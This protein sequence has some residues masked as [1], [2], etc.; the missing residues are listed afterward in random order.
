MNFKEIIQE[1]YNSDECVKNNLVIDFEHPDQRNKL[2]SIIMERFNCEYYVA[3]EWI[4]QAVDK[5]EEFKLVEDDFRNL[6]EA[7]CKRG[8]NPKRDDCTAADGTA[9]SGKEDKE[10]VK[11]TKKKEF[12][13]KVGYQNYEWKDENGKSA[14]PDEIAEMV[15]TST[16]P[17]FI[18]TSD[19]KHINKRADEERHKIFNGEKTGKGTTGTTAQEECANIGREIAARKDFKEPPPLAE[20]IYEEVKKRYPQAIGP[21]PKPY[22]SE[23]DLM[24]ACEKST[25]GGDTMKILQTLDKWDYAEEQ[26]DGM[27][28][29]TTDSTIVRDVLITELKKCEELKN[30]QERKDCVKYYQRELYFFQ[31]KAT[32]KS[33]TGKEGDAD[34]MIIYKGKDGKTRVAYITNKTGTGD[35][36]S[37]STIN[38]TKI[39]IQENADKFFKDPK[40]RKNG[41]KKIDKIVE[42][43][44][45]KAATFNTNFTDKIK[46]FA[47]EDEVDDKGEKT[48]KKKD[49]KK[50]KKLRDPA[51]SKALGKAMSVDTGG[52]RIVYST[53]TNPNPKTKKEKATEEAR[54]KR[55]EKYTKKAQKAPE[56]RA[57]LLGEEGAPNNNPDSK[58]YKAWRTKVNKKWNEHQAQVDAGKK[59]Q[60]SPEDTIQASIDVSGTGSLDGMGTGAQEAPYTIVRTMKATREVREQMWRCLG[61]KGKTPTGKNV[62]K[63]KK[64][65]KEC[66]KKIAKQ[67]KSAKESDKLF[68]GGVFDPEDI[69]AIYG[70]EELEE[71][72]NIHLQ[73][74][75]DIADMYDKTTKE[76]RTEDAEWAKRN[77]V[78]DVPPK[79]GPFTKAYVKGFFDRTHISDYLSGDVDG[80]VISEMGENSIPPADFRRALADTVG[81]PYDEDDPGQPDPEEL[82]AFL[83]ENVVPSE[84]GQ[85]LVYVTKT[86]KRIVIG[87]D[88]HR[89]GGK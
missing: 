69:E 39:S 7:D 53:E 17:P 81:F 47:K 78:K 79:N 15:S 54:K 86:G 63:K 38:G 8:Q 87:I 11:K 26:P 73:R 58:E 72:E 56:V 37:S 21:K 64:D 60:F 68:Y 43:Q 1:L 24:D 20:Q 36:M 3:D 80:R 51:V 67:P 4:S 14:T 62:S 65:I 52:G 22:Q 46:E 29:N 40:E 49:T 44:H 88:T 41:V 28:V 83:M 59:E 70:S 75:S 82:E 77:G 34:T 12:P 76:L 55:R 66:A 2:R 61:D 42:E 19:P 10:K 30:P 31:K 57:K 89:T 50:R 13:K 9:G 18:P 6:T 25:A 71:M 32:D 16:D 23:E 84:D 48:G 45:K 5:Y 33:V 85:E 35:Q 27:P 74:G